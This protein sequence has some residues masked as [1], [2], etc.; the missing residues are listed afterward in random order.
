MFILNKKDWKVISHEK[1]YNPDPIIRRRC[2]VLL[3]R[4]LGYSRTETA[5]IAQVH[6]DTVSD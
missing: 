3:L 1:Y 6:P 5:K 2:E 4:N